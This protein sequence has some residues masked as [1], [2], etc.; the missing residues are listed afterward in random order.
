VT[1]ITHNLGLVL[2]THFASYW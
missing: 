1:A 2:N